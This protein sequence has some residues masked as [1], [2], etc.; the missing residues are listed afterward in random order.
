MGDTLLSTSI[1]SFMFRDA[2]GGATRDICVHYARPSS[3]LNS[4]SIVI[5]MHG[6]DRAAAAFRDVFVAAAERNGQ[7]GLATRRTGAAR[8]RTMRRS[9]ATR[10]TPARGTSALRKPRACGGR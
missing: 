5:A 6:L 10:A 7:M 4:A 1:G 9:T 2:I 8:S 3:D